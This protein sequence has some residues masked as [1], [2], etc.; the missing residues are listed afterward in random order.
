M[1]LEWSCPLSDEGYV[2]HR[3]W[4]G[5]ILE[6]CP[7]HPEGGCGLHKLGTYVRVEP[8]GTRIPRWWCPKRGASV[9]LLPAF[10]AARFSG[11]LATIERVVVA[12]ETAGS[13]AAAVDVVHPP[14]ARDAVGLTCALRS[15]R[16]RVSAVSAA[17]LAIVTLLPDL[18][19]GVQPTIGG[20]REVLACGDVLAALRPIVKRHLATLPAPLGF[21][22][23]VAG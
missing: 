9:S 22:A 6:S 15:I 12:V 17:L 11:T 2:T 19:A 7:F 14:D 5:A 23:R 8:P 21:G 18:F 13:I 4:D 20:F 3:A 1:Q 10:L 16:R